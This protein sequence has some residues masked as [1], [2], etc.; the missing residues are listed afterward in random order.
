MQFREIKQHHLSAIISIVVLFIVD[1][2][3]FYLAYLISEKTT[4][5]FVGIKYPIH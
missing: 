3:A 4:S 2:L 1:I 5:E